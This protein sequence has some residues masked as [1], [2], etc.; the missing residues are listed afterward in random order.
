MFEFFVKG[1]FLM[2]PIALCSVIGLTV[3]INKFIQYRK[4]LKSIEMPLEQALKAR[5]AIIIP[6]IRGD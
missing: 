2:Y 6:H 1:G 3:L 5:P 4:I